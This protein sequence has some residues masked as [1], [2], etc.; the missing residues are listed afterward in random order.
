MSRR[1]SVSVTVSVSVS[2]SDRPAGP[3]IF[4]F[5][6]FV[7]RRTFPAGSVSNSTEIVPVKIPQTPTRHGSQRHSPTSVSLGYITY[8]AAANLTSLSSARGTRDLFGCFRGSSTL[9]TVPARNAVHSHPLF[10]S[11]RSLP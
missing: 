4:S 1:S 7:R 2:V 8:Q 9:S 11:T 6:T 3:V 10:A 5:V